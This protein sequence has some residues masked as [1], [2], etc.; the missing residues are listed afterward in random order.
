[1]GTVA[2]TPEVAYCHRCKWRANIVILARD[3]GLLR[4]NSETAS[5]FREEAQLRMR[6]V[7]EI[8][9]FEAWRNS[10]IRAVSDRY[11]SL[12]RAAIHASAVLT[13]FLACEEAWDALA[14]F[15]HAE[16]QLSAA[17]H[18][19]MFTKASAWLETDSSPVE[20]FETWRRH[21]T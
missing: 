2:F 7:A 21:A 20:V 8:K 5:V 14:R 15:Y 4:G 17:F 9:P 1:M 3:V 16:A 10:G 6:L 11:R 13:K 18:W 12:S 19:L